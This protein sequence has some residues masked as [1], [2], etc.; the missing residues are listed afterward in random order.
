MRR[1]TGLLTLAVTA[2]LGALVVLP[3]AHA[4][5][6]VPSLTGRVVDQAGILSPEQAA[7]LSESL[8]A[9]EKSHGPQIAVLTIPSLEGE[10]IEGF[11]IR[12]VDQ[13]KLGTEK[14][15][16]GVLLLVAVQEHG[17]RIEVG[18][19]LEG[20]LP[21][22]AAGKII[23]DVIVPR[24][25]NGEMAEGI[26]AGSQAIATR[27]GGSLEG[28][29]QPTRVERRREPFPVGKLVLLGFFLLFLLKPRGPRS[30]YHGRGG[31]WGGGHWGGGGGSWGGG[32][33]FSGGGGG[34]SGGG[35][36]GKW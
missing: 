13:W 12:A 3:T 29:P 20:T 34:F 26:I 1:T 21:D 5:R 33:G 16:D 24:F 23:R 22:A 30:R 18:Q 6:S 31:G 7:R 17:I 15:D 11:S 14:N 25:R 19:G 27:L 4:E 32:G 10:S 9:F 28:I 36:S 8:A 2:V 35:A